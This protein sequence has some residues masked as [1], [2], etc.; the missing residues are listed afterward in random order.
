VSVG[1]IC[2]LIGLF[3]GLFCLYTRS[4]LTL[5]RTSGTSVSVFLMCSL[6]GLFL[7]LFWHLWAPQV[8]Q[9]FVCVCSGD[10]IIYIGNNH[11]LNLRYGDDSCQ[12]VGHYYLH[13]KLLFTKPQVW[14]WFVPI[15]PSAPLLSLPLLW[16]LPKP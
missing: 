14:Q 3:L 2:S 6:I 8:W 15:S 1:L 4:L 11:L 5:M 10:I 12:S 7:G 16:Y 9:W 13:R